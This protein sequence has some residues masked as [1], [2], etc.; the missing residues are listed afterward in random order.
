[1]K[2][3][4]N[5][6][7]KLLTTLILSQ[8]LLLP[9]ASAASSDQTQPIPQES[10]YSQDVEYLNN[11]VYFNQAEEPF[12]N[13]PYGEGEFGTIINTGCGPTVMA[14][15]A[16]TL[17]KENISPIEM[18]E[19]SRE[20]GNIMPNNNGTLWQFFYDA[21]ERLGLKAT[22]T[23]SRDEVIKALKEGK[24]VINSVN[25]S[26]GGYWTQYG[27]FILL[28]KAVDG[29][30]AVNDPAYRSKS[31]LHSEEEVFGPSKQMWIIE[32]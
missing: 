14:M 9:I 10:V 25:N 8:G 31:K 11:A 16:S 1:M 18:A 32:K 22:A 24:P 30:I 20:T 19:L 2:F 7:K 17:L 27:H 21:A 6:G 13:Y 23:T 5:I 29:Q 4:K 12:R 28:T 26:M 3:T 15:A